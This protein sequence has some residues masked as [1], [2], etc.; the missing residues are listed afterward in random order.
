MLT[1]IT[2]SL[3]ALLQ[4]G[5]QEASEEQEGMTTLLPDVI[6]SDVHSVKTGLL[7]QA[8]WAL[9]EALEGPDLAAPDRLRPHRVPGIPRKIR[10]SLSRHSRRRDPGRS[11]P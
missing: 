9:P 10:Q 1:A 2:A 8:P 7:F 3:H 5:A 11:M 4:S 6:L